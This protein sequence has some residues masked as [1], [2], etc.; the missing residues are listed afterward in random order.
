M[1]VLQNKILKNFGG[2]LFGDLKPRVSLSEAQCKPAADL[3]A[4]TGNL[5]WP[6][7]R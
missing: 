3:T 6:F 1:F 5:G 7:G 2:F 4:E